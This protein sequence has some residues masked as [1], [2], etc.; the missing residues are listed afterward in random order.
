MISS[1]KT[2]NGIIDSYFRENQ[3]LKI[4]SLF[5]AWVSAVETEKNE[6]GRLAL[7]QK[8]ESYNIPYNAD[9]ED[10]LLKV[11]SKIGI[12]AAATSTAKRV[13]MGRWAMRVAAVLIPLVMIGGAAFFFLNQPA[14]PSIQHLSFHAP[15]NETKKVYLSDGSQVWLK[16]GSGLQYAKADVGNREV[17]LSGKAHFII[18]SNEERP[19]LVNTEHLNIT[20]LGTTFTVKELDKND[21]TQV[22]LE[23]GTVN[24]ESVSGER[25]VLQPGDQLIHNNLSGTA[26]VNQL[27]EF[28]LSL[29]NVWKKERLVFQESSLCQMIRTINA[30]YF[31]KTIDF[32]GFTNAEN[33][34]FSIRFSPG[35]SLEKTLY[36]LR[37]LTGNFNYR[38]EG[39]TVY[40]YN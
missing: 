37:I 40:I 36:I 19:F 25:F 10:A 22:T 23:T 14:V 28:D 32:S 17:T 15:L 21:I 11:H 35:E 20:V 39:S 29:A 9:V 2:Y 13:S 38:F 33:V 4:M 26:V 1:K 12:T 31:G 16:S 6:Q 34:Y 27:D 18:E 24:V 8:F 30:Y 3:S 7:Q 5:F